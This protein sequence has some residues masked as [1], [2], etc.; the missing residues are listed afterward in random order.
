MDDYLDSVES[1]ERALIRSKES[2]HLI[3][4]GLFKLTKFVIN[5]PDL[6]D[7]TDESSQSTE[8]KVIVSSKEESMLVLGLNDTLVVSRGTNSTITKILTQRL[9]LSLVPEVYDPIA[10]VAPFT[11][12]ARL[13]LKDICRVNGQVWDDELP[14]D[15]VDRFLAWCVELPQLAE[16][17]IPRSYFSGPFQHLDLHMFGDGSQD[18]FSAVG[19]LRAHVTCT[20]GEITTE[21]AF[22]LGKA[23][24]APMKVMT[25]PELELQEALLAARLKRKIC[26]AL[27][28]TVDKIFM[29]TDSAIVLQWINSTNKHTIFIASRVSEI[30]EN[31][32]V[33]QWNHVAICDNPADA[34][35]RVMSAEALQSNSWLSGPDFLRTDSVSS[36]AA[37]VTNP[38]K[39]QNINLIPFD[40]FSSYQKLI[41]V[42][43][44]VLRLLPSHDSCRTVDGSIADPVELDKTEHHLEYLVQGE[45]FNIERRDLLDNKSVKRSSRIAEFTPFIGPHCLIRSSGRLRQLVEIDF[46]TKHPIVLVARHTFVKLFLRLTHLKKH[47]QGIDYLRSKVQERYAIPKLRSTLRSTKSNCVLCRKFRAATLQPII[48]D[49]PKERLAYQSPHFTNPGVDY[50]GPFYVI[51]RR[52]TVKR[53]GFL[54]T[55]LTTLVVHIEVV[56]SMDT[57]SCVMGVERFVSRWGTPAMIWSDNGTKFI[58]AEKELRECKEKWNTLNIAAELAHKGI[59]WRFN[60]PSAPHQGGIWERLLRTF[61][62]VLYTILG[63]RRLRDEVLNTTFCL[64]EHALNARPLTPV[65]ADP[66]DL[67]AIAPNH[68]LLG[69][70]A[71]R[72]PCIFGVDEFDH[73]KRYAR[74]QFYANAIWARWFMEFVPALN[75]TRLPSSTSRSVI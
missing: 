37:S 59:K 15:I 31:T 62:R 27:T 47:H 45:S 55:C 67:G 61:N 12:G 71:T 65:S 35:T 68:F 18:V 40:K 54:F 1:P 29:W 56:L 19:F 32:S 28:V 3:Y 22:V 33:D 73:R 38:L 70:Q 13:I 9:V 41:R 53:W 39:E 17:T 26:R 46:D 58:G 2:V 34:D 72:T 7:R 66:S 49:L 51:V 57:S 52:T 69:N 24:V 5:V 8:P 50:F 30:L 60:P 43:A 36:L 21:L 25:V 11:V 4:I 74:A 20:S 23:R 48:A 63:T 75:R 44:Y 16:I 42:T 64:V 14:K 6:A 10:L